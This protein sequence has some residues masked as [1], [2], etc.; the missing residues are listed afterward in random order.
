MEMTMQRNEAK[1]RGGKRKAAAVVLS[2]LG[3]AI[4]FFGAERLPALK[5]TAGISGATPSSAEEY[6]VRKAP[7]VWY[8]EDGLYLYRPDSGG[9]VLLSELKDCGM[10]RM[11]LYYSGK[12][13]A[14]LTTVTEEGDGVYYMKD[15]TTDYIGVTRGNLFYR[16]LPEKGEPGGEVS[17]DTQVLS[18]LVLPDGIPVWLDSNASLWTLKGTPGPEAG[19]PVKIASGIKDYRAAKEEN[20]VFLLN[21]LSKA[22]FYTPEAGRRLVAEGVSELN[23]VSEN[24]DRIYY[25]T[26]GQDLFFIGDFG[27][28]RI[29]DVDVEKTAVIPKTG[30]AYYLKAE[31]TGAGSAGAESAGAESTGVDGNAALPPAEQTELTPEEEELVS[32]RIE[33]LL[34]EMAGGTAAETG[35]QTEAE[36]GQTFR[37]GYFDGT[38]HASLLE[39]VTGVDDS[40]ADAVENDRLIVYTGPKDSY[41]VWFMMGEKPLYTGLS[42]SYEGLM[43]LCPDMSEDVLYVARQREDQIG[44]PDQGGIY[45]MRYTEKGFTNP[46]PLFEGAVII[47]AAREGRV[48]AGTWPE[49]GGATLLIG[50]KK[51]TGHVSSFFWDEN[52]V[53]KDIQLYRNVFRESYYTSGELDRWTEEGGLSPVAYNVREYHGFEDGSFTMLCDYDED[54]MKGTLLWWDGE[55]AP[56]TLSERAAGTRPGQG[57]LD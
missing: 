12:N 11:T 27:T 1:E 25:M 26:E 31:K 34:Q 10:D 3:A 37:L 41:S 28:P 5:G 54:E 2:L 14:A 21:E 9:T 56:V 16:A 6:A 52:G 18:Y 33:E 24:L 39:G 13:P 43:D 29:V 51:A 50:G 20:R 46:E 55:G 45:A 35:T 32:L 47:S 57:E 38:T 23:F 22:Y 49:D 17:L 8:E 48:Y 36:T 53:K 7:A 19:K 15:L 40:R 42:T 30:N 4:A 44:K